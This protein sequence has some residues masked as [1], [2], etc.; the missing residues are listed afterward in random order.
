M[1]RDSSF[2]KIRLPCFAIKKRCI[3][4]NNSKLVSKKKYLN[5][6]GLN[7]NNQMQDSKLIQDRNFLVKIHGIK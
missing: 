2:K 6:F 1:G 3:K 5:N 4:D 7:K